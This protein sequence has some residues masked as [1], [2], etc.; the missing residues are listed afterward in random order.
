MRNFAVLACMAACTAFAA[1]IKKD[2]LNQYLNGPNETNQEQKKEA[3]KAGVTLTQGDCDD[4]NAYYVPELPGF[5]TGDTWPCSYAGTVASNADG[6][7]QDFFW[8]YPA[9]DEDAPVAIWLNGGPGASSTFANFLFSSPLRISQTGDVYEMY[10]TD[11]TWIYQAT[12]IYIDQPVGTGFS[13]GEPLLTTM[14]E[15]ADEFITM[16]TNIWEAFP[17]LQ[18]KPLYM[19]GES[20]AGKYIPRFSWALHENGNFNLAASLVGDPYTAPLTQRT[21]TWIVPEALNI[22]DDTNMP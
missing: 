14:D 9:I 10:T 18:G 7:H 13:Y 20:Y 16:V 4:Q 6:T 5:R 17:Q 2:V 21:H 1:D 11:E 3:P 8:M 12:M 15:A 19:T 22:L